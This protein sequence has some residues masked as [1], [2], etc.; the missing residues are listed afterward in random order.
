MTGIPTPHTPTHHQCLQVGEVLQLILTHVAFHRPT[1]AA[2]A[3]TCRGFREI[4]LDMLWKDIDLVD[5]L[6]VLSPIGWDKDE[7]GMCFVRA[8]T[9]EDWLRFDALA[10]RVRRGAFYSTLSSSLI[11]EIHATRPH[12]VPLLPRIRELDYQGAQLDH[13]LL[14]LGPTLI[15]FNLSMFDDSRSDLYGIPGFFARISTFSPSLTEVAVSGNYAD[16]EIADAVAELLLSLPGLQTIDL[17]IPFIDPILHALA[18]LPDSQVLDPTCTTMDPISRIIIPLRLKSLSI[19]DASI[20][21][22]PVFLSCETCSQL[23]SLVLDGYN[24]SFDMDVR[25]VLQACGNLTLL[26]TLIVTC[27]ARSEDLTAGDLLAIQSCVALRTLSVHIEGS[28]LLTDYDIDALVSKLPMLVKLTLFGKADTPIPATTLR[29]L[30]IIISSCPSIRDINLSINDVGPIPEVNCAVHSNLQ[31]VTL[32]NSSIDDPL[33]IAQFLE[34]L[35]DVTEFEARKVS[36]RD[37]IFVRKRGGGRGRASQ[38]QRTLL[39]YMLY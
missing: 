4:S 20:T 22:L 16:E 21:E 35:S 31:F 6:K 37:F 27:D 33:R 15:I 14:F 9:S 30:L 24:L 3:I 39:S 38:E 28:V 19:G 25:M 2:M 12:A 17:S 11:R 5:L 18:I 7:E 36:H 10:Y 26:E 13:T 23:K 32:Y 8:L 34:G 1:L 29:S